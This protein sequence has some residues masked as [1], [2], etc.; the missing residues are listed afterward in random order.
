MLS[1][2]FTRRMK[3]GAVTK[4]QARLINFYASIPLVSVL[5]DAVNLLDLDRAK[6]IRA[7]IREKAA[8]A[9]I[10]INEVA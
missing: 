5:D 1:L 10:T 6:F 3:R 4:K 8:R 7:A 2:Y 9:G